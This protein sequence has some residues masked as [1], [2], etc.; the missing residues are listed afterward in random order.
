MAEIHEQLLLR[1]FE[2]MAEEARKRNASRQELKRLGAARSIMS[3]YEDDISYLHAGFCLAGLPHM[4]PE[5]DEARWVRSNG[6]FHLIITPG[7]VVTEGRVKVVGVPYGAKARQ[8]SIVSP[9][10]RKALETWVFSNTET[11]KICS[12]V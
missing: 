5:D 6:K 7:A 9:S 8:L 11:D 3:A 4:R 1:G 2:R 12:K 10:S